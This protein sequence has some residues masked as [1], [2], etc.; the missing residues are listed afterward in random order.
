[1]KTQTIYRVVYETGHH[2]MSIYDDA[3]LWRDT[4]AINGEIIEIL[5]EIEENNV[6]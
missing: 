2:D 4:N 5:I 3:K 1:M 6:V